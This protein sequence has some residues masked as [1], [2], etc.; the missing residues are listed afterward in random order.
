[1]PRT[2]HQW[3]SGAALGSISRTV[4]YE[5]SNE[6]LSS[7]GYVQGLLARYVGEGE[8]SGFDVSRCVVRASIILGRLPCRC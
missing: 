4:G 5:I 3:L 2:A 6:L 8:P 7:V 1:M